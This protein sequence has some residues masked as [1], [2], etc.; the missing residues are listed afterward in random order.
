MPRKKKKK[1]AIPRDP[2]AIH[3]RGV[4]KKQYQRCVDAIAKSKKQGHP[5]TWA[6]VVAAGKCAQTRAEKAG[7][8]GA[9]KKLLAD[10]R[11]H[12]KRKAAA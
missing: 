10:V 12:K 8:N 9:V 7:D 6:D 4:S 3:A 2:D 5:I 11:Q 1:K